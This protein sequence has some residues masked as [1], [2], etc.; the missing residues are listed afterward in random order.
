MFQPGTHTHH[1]DCGMQAHTHAR[2]HTHTHTH[3]HT[4]HAVI[5][6]VACKVVLNCSASARVDFSRSSSDVTDS[7]REAIWGGGGGQRKE[8]MPLGQ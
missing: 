1:A 3:T 4:Q 2:T 7:S 6:T 5:L 8:M